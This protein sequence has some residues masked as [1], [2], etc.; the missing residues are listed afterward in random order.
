MKRCSQCDITLTN[1]NCKPSVLNGRRNGYCRLCSNERRRSSAHH[2]QYAARWNREHKDQRSEIQHRYHVSHLQVRSVYAA[3]RRRRLE[4][5]VTPEDFQEKFE[6]QNGL[7]E[8]CKK[9]FILGAGNKNRMRPCQDHDHVTGE[10]R[11]L[12]CA[13]CN[14]ILGNSFESKEILANA[15]AYL[16]KHEAAQD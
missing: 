6:K 11:D 7:C 14:L 5:G 3:D 15:I 16:Q 2:K 9:P 8:I 1:E 10:L 12:L 4:Y 13:S